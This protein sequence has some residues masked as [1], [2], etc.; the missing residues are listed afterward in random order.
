[1]LYGHCEAYGVPF[2]RCGKIIVATDETQ[3]ETLRAYQ[4]RAI[5]NG[6]GELR[7][8]LPAEV[9]ELEPAVSC[10]GAVLSETTGIIDSH[11][12]MESLVGDLE[13]HDGVIAFHS[14]VVSGAPDRGVVRG[15][16]KIGRPEPS[17]ASR[18]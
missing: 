17:S 9:A 4:R 1:M 7:W 6:V 13:A 8:L 5:A 10:A 16:A 2:Q 3:L 12:F 14:E 11:A 15:A 18:C